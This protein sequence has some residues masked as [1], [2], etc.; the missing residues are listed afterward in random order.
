MASEEDCG[1]PTLEDEA[2]EDGVDEDGMPEVGESRTLSIRRVPS[3]ERL[4][5]DDVMP[6]WPRECANLTI[7]EIGGV[8]LDGINSLISKYEASKRN[9]RASTI[10]MLATREE[11]TVDRESDLDPRDSEVLTSNELEIL[12]IEAL[13]TIKHKIGTTS[14]QHL[15]GVEDLFDYVRQAF[16]MSLED[17]D[18][19]LLKV[20][21]EKP[22]IVVLEV[23]VVDAKALEAKDADGFSDPYCMLGIVPGAASVMTRKDS[24]QDTSALSRLAERRKSSTSS[25][26]KSKTALD[27]IPARFIKTT[28]VQ[29][30]TLNPVWNE[31]FRFDLED[32]NVDRMHMDIWDHDDEISVLDSARKLNEVKGLKGLGRYFKQIAQSAR[33]NSEGNTDDFLGSV[34]LPLV[35]M[36]STGL[37]K[38][39][40]LTG[41]SSKS[42]VEGQVHLKLNLATREDRGLSEEDILFETRQHR[43]LLSVFVN[44]EFSKAKEE[45]ESWSGELSKAAT[46]ILHQ[47]AIQGDMTET[48]QA[49]C[50]WM[51]YSHQFRKKSFDWQIIAKCLDDVEEKWSKES[52]FKEEEE[53]LALSFERFI[54]HCLKVV[55]RQNEQLTAGTKMTAYKLEGVLS[56]LDKIYSTQIFARCCPFVKPLKQQLVQIVKKMAEDRYNRLQSRRRSGPTDDESS[57]KEFAN[58][59]DKL[60]SNLYTARDTLTPVYMSSTEFEY[61]N[62]WYKQTHHLSVE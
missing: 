35:D 48:Q 1:G 58:M 28:S 11:S 59:M 20:N 50:T 39:F 9:R 41:R 38:L 17:H 31:K 47:H 61:F 4:I 23:T 12:Y 19:L 60:N 36:P 55:A 8:F 32:V 37:D 56:C 6:C 24:G 15:S 33:T 62:V 27:Q 53:A 54:S 3:L 10:P 18:R 43:D 30:N 40:D 25:I 16:D 7:S 44:Y 2:P 22:P 57:G 26:K 13:Y 21:E 42:K 45:G 5:S 46:T 49:V 52:L 29:S 14:D 34:D 51:A